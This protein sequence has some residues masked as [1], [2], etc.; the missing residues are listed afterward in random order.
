VLIADDDPSIQLFLITLVRALGA[1]PLS[2]GDGAA[3]IAAVAAHGPAIAVVLLDHAMPHMTGVE[4]ALVLHE[5]APAL[6]IIMASAYLSDADRAT[7]TAL[8][9]A[10]IV[11]KPF[12]LDVLR[13]HLERYIAGGARTVGQP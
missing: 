10:A 1:E 9:V 4:A 12:A 13:D 3:A 7:L 5:S 11:D 6:P 8:P 2:V